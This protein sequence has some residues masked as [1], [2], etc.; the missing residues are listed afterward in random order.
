VDAQVVQFFLA[1]N[2]EATSFAAHR[3]AIDATQ[4]PETDILALAAAGLR[5]APNARG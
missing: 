5:A 4:L 1:H 3:S 2:G